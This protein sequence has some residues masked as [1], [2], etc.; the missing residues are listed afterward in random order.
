[1]KKML[2]LALASLIAAAFVA[3]CSKPA[4]PDAAATAGATAGAA[5]AATAGDAK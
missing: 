4:E 3:G 5:P 1:M 2:T